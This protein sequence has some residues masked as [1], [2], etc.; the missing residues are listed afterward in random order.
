MRF[1]WSH[2]AGTRVP[3]PTVIRYGGWQQLTGGRVRVKVCFC[4]LG[5]AYASPGHGPSSTYCGY[6]TATHHGNHNE[7]WS[8]GCGNESFPGCGV[9]VQLRL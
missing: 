1:P 4:A 5:Q 7:G 6:S 2:H 3:L 9:L 8:H